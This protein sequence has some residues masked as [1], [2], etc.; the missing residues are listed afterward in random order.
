M[1]VFLLRAWFFVNYSF[2]FR[3]VRL[4]FVAARSY[5]IITKFLFYWLLNLLF[6]CVFSLVWDFFIRLRMFCFRKN[7][8]LFATL[9]KIKH[10]KLCKNLFFWFWPYPP[11]LILPSKRVLFQGK[12]HYRFLRL[13]RRYTGSWEVIS[14]TCYYTDCYKNCASEGFDPYLFPN[15]WPIKVRRSTGSYSAFESAFKTLYYL[16]FYD[17]LGV[18]SHHSL[19]P[20]THPKALFFP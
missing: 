11:I 1:S 20:R 4:Y 15:A 9:S 6:C 7:H 19:R 13:L 12:L 17:N 18:L 5:F 10:R 2:L 14:E 8:E 16:L 3:A